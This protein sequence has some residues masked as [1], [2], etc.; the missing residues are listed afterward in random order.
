[1]R[2]K[3]K[4]LI[5]ISVSRNQINS[6]EYIKILNLAKCLG[7][8]YN[9]RIER[10]DLRIKNYDLLSKS[11]YSKTKRAFIVFVVCQNNIV[12]E[13]QY[14]EVATAL[15]N[16]I[17]TLILDSKT[18]TLYSVKN[19]KVN[20][21]KVNNKFWNLIISNEPVFINKLKINQKNKSYGKFRKQ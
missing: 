12:D 9:C 20:P 5:Y 17:K 8:R 3:K 6:P 15:V 2:T 21:N 14:F 19:F 10:S 4:H 16:N 13:F 11:L 7:K 1:M 18:N